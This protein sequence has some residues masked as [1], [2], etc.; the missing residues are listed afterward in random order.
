MRNFMPRET[1]APELVSPS[2]TSPTGAVLS[3]EKGI[4]RK[5]GEYW[6]IGYGRKAFRLKDSKGLAYLARLL[7]H[8]W[9]EFHALD[10][11]GATAGRNASE[12]EPHRPNGALPQSAE[13]LESAGIHMGGLGDGGELLEEPAKAAYRRRLSE[14]RE[15]VEEAKQFDQFERAA[16]AEQEIEALTAELS[17]AVGRNGRNRH[18]ASAA[19]R[20]RQ[21]VAKAIK[22]VAE[23]IAEN[24]STLGAFFSRYIRTGTFCSYNP[25]PNSPLAWE[26]GTNTSDLAAFVSAL[27]NATEFANQERPE[28]AISAPRELLRPLLSFADRTTFVGREAERSHLRTLVD[29][30]FSGQGSLVM[31]GGGPGVGKTRLAMEIGRA[32]TRQGFRILSGRCYEREEPHPYVPFAEILETALTQASSLEEFR[33]C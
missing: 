3:V 7:R 31:L 10:L 8:P 19:E 17:R 32:A 14:L 2:F 28:Q 21:S 16:R 24:D 1:G 29:R 5:E 4:F 6:T 26:F 33:E 23:R 22:T 11:V 30:A 25:D 9:T 20:A 27:G 18:A 15:E 13:E 12:E